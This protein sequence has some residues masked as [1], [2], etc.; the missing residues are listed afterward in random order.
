MSHSESVTLPYHKQGRPF[1]LR[2]LGLILLAIA[3]IAIYRLVSALTGS[4]LFALVNL[5]IR[6]QVYLAGSG[7]F[8]SLA[9]VP[10]LWGL[11]WRKPWSVK[12]TW[13]ATLFYLVTYWMERLFLW[14]DENNTQTL[15]FY[16][17]LSIF[18]LGLNFV[19]FKLRSTRRFL[20][21]ENDPIPERNTP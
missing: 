18:W 9:C 2:L 17:A 21:L 1:F 12:A 15:V 11:T 4:A 6:L 3:V 7:L 16:A 14:Q 13:V 19:T 20:H 10:P 8:W 5:P